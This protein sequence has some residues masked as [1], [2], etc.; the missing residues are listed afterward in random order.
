MLRFGAICLLVV[1]GASCWSEDAPAPHALDYPADLREFRR[2]ALSEDGVFAP[3]I[4]FTVRT[5]PYCHKPYVFG[6]FPRL[7]RQPFDSL[8]A[9]HAAVE[10]CLQR[11][12]PPTMYSPRAHAMVPRACPHCGEREEHAAPDRALFCH[13]LL[14]TGDDL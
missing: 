8:A 2:K 4:V 6:A 14:E 3:D 9:V 1:V 10:E 5:C 7:S 13:G 11:P 12:P